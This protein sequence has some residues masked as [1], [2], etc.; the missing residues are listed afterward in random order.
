MRL[1]PP[2]ET[3]SRHQFWLFCSNWSPGA[4]MPPAIYLLTQIS[5]KRFES[6]PSHF[7]MLDPLTSKM[8]EVFISY[9]KNLGQELRAED[10]TLYVYRSWI[11][12]R[13][14]R[15]A[16]LP[17]DEFDFDG[18]VIK[19]AIIKLFQEV[20]YLDRNGRWPIARDSFTSGASQKPATKK[21][22]KS[23]LDDQA[24]VLRQ[25]YEGRARRLASKV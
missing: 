1:R 22:V 5:T 15:K 16:L 8:M 19:E 10:I 25:A 3:M 12:R 24:R 6:P 9:H 17:C 20:G 21:R 7:K 13:F 14:D 23:P 18:S 4:G 11:I 2:A